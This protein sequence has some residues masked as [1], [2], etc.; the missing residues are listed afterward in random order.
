MNI[1]VKI[2]IF[3]LNVIYSFI[4]LFKTKNKIT[5]ISRQSNNIPIDFKLLKDDLN[6][7]YPD[8][9]VVILCKDLQMGFIG[10]ILYIFHMF[11]QMYHIATSKVVVLD[12]YCITISLLK[13]KKSL[14]VIQ[15]WHALGAFKKFGYSVQNKKE[16]TN[17]KI[18]KLMRMHKNYNYI[19]SS[20]PSCSKFFAQAFGYSTDQVVSYPLPRL[21]L[22]KDKNYIK[23][24]ND[25]ILSKYPS[26]S[27][28]KNIL[29]APTFRINKSGID[30][31]KKSI[32]IYL[33]KLINEIDFDK[34]NLI[35]KF[36]PL[37]DEQI[38]DERVICDNEYNTTDFLNIVDYVITDYSA[39]IYEVA[40][41][42]KPVYFYDFD[43]KEYTENRDFYLD[44]NKDM[45][46]L[47]TDD[48]KIIIN[49]INNNEYDISK[50]KK[51]S[52]DNIIKCKKSYTED[53]SDFIIK[54]ID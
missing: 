17:T 3:C 2:C 11:R 43:I 35:V 42:L 24:I 4:K 38:S 25:K 30:R 14:V 47:V 39:I 23:E 15:M 26:L 5:F 54:N 53:I 37:S 41:L 18:V 34:Y 16:G 9:K 13:H 46:G 44:I 40:Y 49:S 10:K 48:P 12:S 7:R 31:K 8:Y 33:D 52:N 32:D 50:I 28:K 27:K 21:D 36:H 6:K 20:S 1:I 45:P 19:F 22:L 51:F 29:Y